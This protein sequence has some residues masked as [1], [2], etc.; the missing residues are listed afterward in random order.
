[1]T[2]AEYTHVG[3][4][5]TFQT[6]V[7]Q[8]HVRDAALAA[9]GEIVHDI[10]CKDERFNRPETAGVASLMR[11]VVHVHDDDRERITRGGAILDDLYAT[12]SRR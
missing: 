6:L 7:R 8:F 9:I 1:M 11:G 5:C 10:D 4:E 3:D 12:F 2:G